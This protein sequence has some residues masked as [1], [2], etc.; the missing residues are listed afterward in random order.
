MSQG[1]ELGAKARICIG[2]GL[3]ELGGGARGRS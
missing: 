1:K 3:E 2:Q